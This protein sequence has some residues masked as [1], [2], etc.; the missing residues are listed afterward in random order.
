MTKQ[1]IIDIAT[2]WIEKAYYSQEPLEDILEGFVNAVFES[3]SEDSRNEETRNLDEAAEE[4]CK[5][6][7]K[8]LALGGDKR[9]H[10]LC[11]GEDAFKAGAE[12]MA[13]QGI[14]F[15]DEACSL[16]D[17]GEPAGYGFYDTSIFECKEHPSDHE[18]ISNLSLKDGDKVIIQIR[19]K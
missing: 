9:T 5:A 11:D 18:I 17:N 13:G 12:W 15:E 7:N 14:S 19:K 16:Y 10:Y 1:Q 4:W 8:G 6:N 3:Y 2:E